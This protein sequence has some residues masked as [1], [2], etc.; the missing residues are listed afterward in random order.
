MSESL[1]I[2]ATRFAGF[3]A[4]WS[5]PPAVKAVQPGVVNLYRAKPERDC[6]Q[7]RAASNHDDQRRTEPLHEHELLTPLRC[8]PESKSELIARTNPRSV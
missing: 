6:K 7:D 5:L 4:D 1:K 3:A 8:L 2:F